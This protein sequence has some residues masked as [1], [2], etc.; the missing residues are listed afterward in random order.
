MTLRGFFVTL[1]GLFLGILAMGTEIREFYIMSLCM[2]GLIAYSLFSL[3]LALFTL[4]VESKIN[5]GAALRE[6]TVNYTLHLNGVAVFPVVGYISVKSADILPKQQ[7]RLKHSLLLM[8]SF[9]TKRKFSFELPCS[10]I[11]AWQVGIRK[12]RFEDIFGLFSL[13]LLRNEKEKFTAD[14][15]VMPKIHIIEEAQDSVS[16]GGYGNSS[17]SNAEEGEL[18]GDSRLYREGDSLKR[19]NWK[20]SARAKTLYSRQYEMLQKPKIVI[21][22][23]TAFA[24]ESLLDTVDL[25]FETAITIGNY[26]VEELNYVELLV[27]RSKDET[28]NLIFG[29]KSNND[30]IKM[31]YDFSNVAYRSGRDALRLDG[32]EDIYFLNADKIY[33]ITD[34]PSS[35]LISD[36]REMN[37]NGKI[38]RCI[39]PKVQPTVQDLELEENSNFV[40]VIGSAQKISK[41]AGAIL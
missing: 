2:G 20:Q 41:K 36:I 37:K 25:A 8:P 38:V 4:K 40:T 28:E 32:L 17:F 6:E 31:Q 33:F 19:I 16:S 21:A 5:K 22:V 13:P 30:I 18:L 23:D 15:A 3:L 29:L 26:F 12:L 27:L 35:E 11:G 1:I 24:S 10:H 39:I 7:N 34:N 14:L 9:N